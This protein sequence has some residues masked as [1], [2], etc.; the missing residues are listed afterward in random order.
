MERHGYQ[1]QV[2]KEPQVF[3]AQMDSKV[4]KVN[5]GQDLQSLVLYQM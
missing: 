3:K 4:F 5:M 1:F 2:L